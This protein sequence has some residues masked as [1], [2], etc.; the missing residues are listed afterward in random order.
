MI[1][2]ALS[3]AFV[4]FIHSLV[5]GHWLPVVLVARG[6]RW[7]GRQALGGALLAASGHI[8]ISI[9]VGIGIVLIGATVL[10]GHLERMER[11]G[12]VGAMVFGAFYALW[13]YRTHRRCHGHGHH[14]P[15]PPAK[16]RPWVFLLSMGFSPCVAVLPVFAAAAGT[17]ASALWV[18]I[19]SFSLG[20]VSAMTGAILVTT[21]GLLQLDHPWLEHYGDVIA[22]AVVFL[23]GLAL[24]VLPHSH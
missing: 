24:F 21:R 17:G 11:A 19:V 16:V 8:L 13:A 20:V 9:I 4:G 23:M 2:V 15:K 6:R 12:S 18:A 22:G 1:L 10:E 14:G 7:S 3:S 5:P